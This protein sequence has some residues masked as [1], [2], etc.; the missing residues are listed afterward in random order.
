VLRSRS[1]GDGQGNGDEWKGPGSASSSRRQS[2]EIFEP[3]YEQQRHAVVADAS[4]SASAAATAC[5]GDAPH[6]QSLLMEGAHLLRQHS[7][8]FSGSESAEET[9]TEFDSET[10]AATAQEVRTAASDITTSVAQVSVSVVELPRRG[11]K[12]SLIHAAHGPSSAPQRP[13]CNSRHD[14][15]CGAEGATE[16]KAAFA[17]SAMALCTTEMMEGNRSFV[18]VLGAAG[19]WFCGHGYYCSY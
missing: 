14:L 5:R 3:V 7:L 13:V 10:T 9:S 8:S 15:A 4:A 16:S 1:R 17:F 19:G 12:D 18:Y 11:S 6:H 2:T